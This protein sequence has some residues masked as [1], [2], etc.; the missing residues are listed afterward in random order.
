MKD[1]KDVSKYALSDLAE[2]LL[3]GMEKTIEAGDKYMDEETFKAWFMN[4]KCKMTKKKNGYVLRGN[5]KT[6]DIGESYNGPKIVAVYGN[7]AVS[8]TKLSNLEGLFTDDCIVEGTFTIENND[9]LVSLKGCPISVN[10][11]VIANNKSLMDIDIA[12]N[13][14]V[15]AYVSKNGKKFKETALRGKMNVYKKIFCSV[16][17][18]ENL[19]NES[20]TIN[21]AFKAPQLKLIADALKES[22]K[23]VKDEYD[24]VK[25]NHL[26]NIRWDMIEA[27][28]ISEYDMSDPKSMTAARGFV[29]KKENSNGMYILM[30]NDQVTGIIIDK[31]LIRFKSFYT[32][33]MSINR[34]SK[35]SGRSKMSNQDI[36]DWIASSDIFMYVDLRGVEHTYNIQRDRR[37]ARSG[38]IAL[39]RGYERTG[40][41]DPNRWNVSDRIDAKQVRYYQNVADRN[42][43]R[44]KELVTKI[45]AQKALAMGNFEKI[46]TRL[47]KAFSR[48]T[49]LLLK[50]YKEPQKYSS[51]DIDWLND[52]FHNM[53]RRDKWSMNESGLFYSIERYFN[54]LVNASQGSS[55]TRSSVAEDLKRLEEA[56]GSSLDSVEVMLNRL[57][58]K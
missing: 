26:K 43:A 11:L 41:Y 39:D 46:K 24:K 30:K 40:K 5:F 3:A 53:T 4:D 50:V 57:E 14:L 48:Y 54:Y 29:Y 25:F 47:D 52:K 2:G 1:I 6:K 19:I 42:R 55:Y 38:A 20:E 10:T 58:Q 31:E 22:S 33:G 13:V 21:E 23:E 9:D 8:N 15:N 56:I 27:S 17:N 36:L 49:S 28:Q 35:Y 44:Y 32:G 34:V 51:Y 45:K 12:P 16:E 7:F 18:E 37:E